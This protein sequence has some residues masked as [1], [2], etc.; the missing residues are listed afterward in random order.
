MCQ[1]LSSRS[2]FPASVCAPEARAAFVPCAVVP[3]L[4]NHLTLRAVVEGLRRHGLPVF[5][6]DDGSATAT[7]AVADS[8]ASEGL[9]SVLR[10]ERNRGKGAA[11]RTGMDAART[12]GFTHAFQVDA[13]GQHDLAQVPTFLEAAAGDP[14][15]LVL[16]Y[17]VF[18]ASVPRSRRLARQITTFWVGLELGSWRAVRDALIG[19]RIYPLAAMARV[20]RVADR[21]GFDFEAAVRLVRGGARPIN[22]P[23]AVRYL[24]VEEGGLSHIRPFRDNLAFSLLHARLCI[25]GCC[26]WLG[27][28]TGILR[29]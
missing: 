19:F 7:R 8:L 13:D 18:D 10:H 4:D 3:T 2:E 24:K 9:A 17:P 15:A 28:R 22:L 11:C 21:M 29:R 1:S 20:P 16:A 27:R 12:L 5:V 25:E 6:V 14:E 23:V 26:A